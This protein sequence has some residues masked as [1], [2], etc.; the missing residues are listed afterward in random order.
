MPPDPER[1]SLREA[2]ERWCDPSLVEAVRAQERRKTAYEMDQVS[3][4]IQLTPKTERE[5]PSDTRWMVGPPDYTRLI[6]A[7]RELESDLR[8]MISFG[9]IHLRGVQTR[10]QRRS[11][12]EPIPSAWGGDA[13]FDFASSAVEFGEYR[14]TAV[15]C[16]RHP[17]EPVPRKEQVPLPLPAPDI[18][19]AVIRPEDV[20]GLSDETILALLEEH[21]RRVVEGPEVRLGASLTFSLMPLVQRKL[22]HRAVRGEMLM[23]LADETRWLADWIAEKAPSFHVPQAKPIENALRGDYNRLKAQANGMIA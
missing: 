16:A 14:F 13:A 4:R 21:A 6:I 22:R 20:P 5:R 17:F 15:L 10:P 23:S 8:Q 19:P 9:A 18:L 1:L 11:D 2:L 3:H 12:P 7:W